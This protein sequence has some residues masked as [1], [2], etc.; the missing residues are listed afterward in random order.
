MKYT[1]IKVTCLSRELD[2]VSAVMSAIDPALMIEDY[3]DIEDMDTCYGELI[4]ESLLNADREHAWVSLFLTEDKSAADTVAFLRERFTAEG[5]ETAI[6][7]DGV[8]E[9]DWENEWRKYY[10]PVHIGDRIT[11]VPAWQ[12][13]DAREDEVTV[14]MD[15]GLAFGTGTHETTRL[16]ATLLEKYMSEG[17]T[18]L[19]VGTGS[20]ILAI[21]ARKLGAGETAG[22]DID[23]VA[24]RVAKEN[25]TDNGEEINFFVSD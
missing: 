13:Y 24:V 16:C 15:P 11:V 2:R 7:V 5:L 10:H 4:D 3:S 25:A 17:D 8:D 22:T 18:V 21:I 6:S 12:E 23:P 14:K 19:D 20:G 9:A 1:Q